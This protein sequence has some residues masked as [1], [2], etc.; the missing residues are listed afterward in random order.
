MQADSSFISSKSQGKSPHPNRQLNAKESLDILT[1]TSGSVE[2]FTGNLQD[3]SNTNTTDTPGDINLH[4]LKGTDLNR[5]PI[6]TDTSGEIGYIYIDEAPLAHFN[7]PNDATSSAFITN[8]S[9]NV[10]IHGSHT[11]TPTPEHETA[12]NLDYNDL[13]WDYQALMWNIGDTEEAEFSIYNGPWE[14]TSTYNHRGHELGVMQHTSEQTEFIISV[15]EAL[16]ELIDLDFKQVESDEVGDIRIFRAYSNSSWDSSW[17]DPSLIGGGYMYGQSEGIDLEWRDIDSDDAFKDVEKSTIV[18]EIG[19]AL[20]LDHPGGVGDNPAWDEWDSI[21]SYNDRPGVS[22]EPIWFSDLDIQALQNIWGIEDDD[23][24]VGQS[25]ADSDGDGFV[26]AITNYQMWTSSGGV[27]LKNRRGRTYSDDTSR[28]WDAV[29]AV[30]D[31]GGFSILVEGQR[32][33]EG[34]F[35]VVSADQEGVI[36]RATRWL[37]GNQMLNEGYEELFAMD[38]N[39]NSEIGI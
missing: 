34:K 3:L 25:L 31:G 5:I 12:D 38:F 33:K 27:D 39:S 14:F 37:N 8:T 16:D 36:G 4:F 23:S 1:D 18:H 29:K 24:D 30:E 7:M 35:K 2:L 28:K 20:G 19:H 11:P 10:F 21:M 32:N 22:K 13:I 17:S 15:F 26:D 9:E 6:T